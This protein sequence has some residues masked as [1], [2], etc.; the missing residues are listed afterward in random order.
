[1]KRSDIGVTVIIYA[2]T[3]FFLVMTLDLPSDAQTYPLCLI[4][5]LLA[6]NTLYLARCLLK[7]RGGAGT[8]ND[9]PEVF[10]GFQWKQF[11]IVCLSCV[12]YMGVMELAGFYIASLLYLAGML[13]Y[14]GVPKTHVL[15][16]ITVM[17]VMIYSVFSLFLKVPLPVGLL[18]K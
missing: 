9:L 2:F 3:L 18:F 16:T 15:L 8:I 11:G 12:L 14:L 1:M 10:A 5:G 6:L 17:A 7:A 13:W 4:G